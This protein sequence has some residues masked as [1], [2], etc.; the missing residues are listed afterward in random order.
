[1]RGG[2]RRPL[3]LASLSAR[4]RELVEDFIRSLGV[5]SQRRTSKYRFYLGKIGKDLSKPFEGASSEDL[6]QY[7]TRVNASGYADNTKRD[8][9]LIVKKF[10]RWLRDE[11]FVGWIR[12]GNPKATVSPED[13]LSDLELDNLR[14][15]CKN[16]RNKALVET[17]YESALRPHEFLGLRKSDVV[18]DNL[19]GFVN[20]AKGK[21]GGRRVRLVNAVPLLANW[22]ENHPLRS[23]DSPLWVDL[24]HGP[25]ANPLKHS[26]LSIVLRTLAHNAG[27][28]KKIH[29]YIFRH[30][31][32]TNL[33]KS[34][35]EAQLCEVAGWRQGS[36]M[37]AMYVHFSGRDVDDAILK[38]HGLKK[39]DE[40]PL[41]APSKCVRCGT[42]C[43]PQEEFC[44]KCGMALS[45]HAVMRKDDERAHDFQMMDKRVN[46]L[47]ANVA[48][49]LSELARRK[50]SEQTVLSKHP[51]KPKGGE[52]VS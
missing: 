41:K 23:G 52:R 1:M 34:M 42:V 10:F 35:T 27:L 44:H 39:P 14:V 13:V 31:R 8:I 48:L 33:A 3:A 24:S 28:E 7:I 9:R 19:G 20:V 11:R 50:S 40:V 38:A 16:L 30:T 29:P 12:T 32:L 36:E 18:F 17:L 45:L 6:R 43:N 5:L 21:T 2:V 49:L 37:P 47:S 46:E 51:N 22:I 15:A 26:G 25:R 4:D